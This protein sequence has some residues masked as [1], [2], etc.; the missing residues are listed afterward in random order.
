MPSVVQRL[1]AAGLTLP[2]AATPVGSYVPA[3]RSGSLVFTSGQLPVIDGEL[4]ASG[5]IG[6]AV[7]LEAAQAC[8]QRCA[9]NCLAAAATVCD[10]DE[11]VSA[12]KL[13]GFVASAPGFISQPAVINGASEVL[14]LAF[15]D[16]GKHAREAVGVA[17]LP[18]GA[19]VEVS[20]VLA[21]G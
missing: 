8:A 14:T 2:V 16:A 15:G 17:A 19:P 18:L 9:L 3:T 21:L 11:V 1:E 7:S 4:M 12:V 20:L 5:L 10:L 6:D 13:V